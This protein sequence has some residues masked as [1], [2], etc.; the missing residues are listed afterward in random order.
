MPF[1]MHGLRHLVQKMKMNVV[2]LSV[3]Y[4]H[5]DLDTIMNQEDRAVVL[6]RNI[7]N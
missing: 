7:E 4:D 3:K 5:I 2:I 6:I 1:I